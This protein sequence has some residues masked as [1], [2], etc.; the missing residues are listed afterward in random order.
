MHFPDSVDEADLLSL[1]DEDTAAQYTTPDTDETFETAEP[2]TEETAEPE[3]TEEEETTEKKSM[4]R[5]VRKRA[6]C[7][8]PVT[9]Q[10]KSEKLYFFN[11]SCDML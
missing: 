4:V 6:V 3:I 11:W 2:K 8:S 1:M 9:Y 7:G 5:G 10:T